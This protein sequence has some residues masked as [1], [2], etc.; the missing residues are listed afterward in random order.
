MV[1]KTLGQ[2]S[3]NDLSTIKT[4]LSLYQLSHQVQVLNNVILTLQEMIT[5][6]PL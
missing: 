6:L 1:D 4:P 3:M 5:N 2:R